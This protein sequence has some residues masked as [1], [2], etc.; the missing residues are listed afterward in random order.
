MYVFIRK[1][2][3]PYNN[4]Y[5]SF[6]KVGALEMVAYFAQPLPMNKVLL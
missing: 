1:Y 5:S 2:I 4:S 6:N 3:L